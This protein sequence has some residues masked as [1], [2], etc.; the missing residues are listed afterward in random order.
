MLQR[1]MT[2]KA[3]AE[4]IGMSPRWASD[5]KRKYDLPR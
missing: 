2:L 5:I 1:G 4:I 3:A